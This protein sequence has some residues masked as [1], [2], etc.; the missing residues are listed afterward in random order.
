MAENSDSQVFFNTCNQHN[1]SPRQYDTGENGDIISSDNNNTDNNSCILNRAS[2]RTSEQLSEVEDHQ[3]TDNCIPLQNGKL[4]CHKQPRSN[5]RMVS[6]SPKSDNSHKHR[7]RPHGS[8]SRRNKSRS[9][10]SRYHRQ[11]GIRYRS[12]SSDMSP[13]P[14]RSPRSH[15]RHYQS[16]P[17][18]C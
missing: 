11:T 9:R 4:S 5:T 1:I 12:S 2:D 17:L 8:H 13:S 3:I 18:P 7:R 15:N 16:S 6:E 14:M 10:S